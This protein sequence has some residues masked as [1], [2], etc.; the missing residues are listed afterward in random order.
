MIIVLRKG[1]TQ[2]E[3][4]EVV[5]LIEKQGLRAHVSKG[6][7]R[8]IIGAIGDERLLNK[9]QLE[10]HPAVEKVMPILKPYKI[11]SREFNPKDT[12][13]NVDGVKIGGDN[14]TVAAGPCTVESEEQLLTTAHAVK[15]A[16]AKILRGSVYKPRTSPYEFQGLGDEGLK[17]LKK[18][19]QETGLVI[20]TEVMDVRKVE[21]VAKYVDILH[22]GARNMQNYD[23]LKE[24]GKVNKPVLLKNGFAST[25]NEFLMAAEY[26]LSNGNHQVILC[27]RGIRT[28]ETETRF[29]L[30]LSAVPVIKKLS[31]LPVIVD[32]SHASGQR[33]LVAAMSKGALAVGA[34]G[35]LVEVH[36]DP[37][38]AICDG[39][40]SMTTDGFAQMMSDLKK[41]APIVGKRM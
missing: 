19:K 40:Q 6:T 9:E 8:T 2:K 33:D 21:L 18:A 10:E 41:M 11:A 1:F 24:V 13:I 32:P 12:V 34:D 38:K 35:L 28:F 16:G 23:L 20:E 22:V 30:D 5:K 26:I 36:C 3:L 25:I 14:F 39:K 37:A 29:T 27:E 31:H 7:E 17:L 4:E 15:K